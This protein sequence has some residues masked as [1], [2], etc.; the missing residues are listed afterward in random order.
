M[1]S[2]RLID[3]SCVHTIW[4]NF[5]ELLPPFTTSQAKRLRYT[6]S[7]DRK[8]FLVDFLVDHKL[9]LGGTPQFKIRWQGYGAEADTWEPLAHVL[10]GALNEYLAKNRLTLQLQGQPSSQRPVFRIRFSPDFQ[11]QEGQSENQ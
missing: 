7:L 8:N 6:R 1:R 4:T 2:R 3:P 10:N 5:L 11:G 9:G